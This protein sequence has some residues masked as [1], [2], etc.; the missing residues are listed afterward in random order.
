MLKIRKQ[1]FILRKKNDVILINNIANRRVSKII[2][3][4]LIRHIVEI[5]SNTIFDIPH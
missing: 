2:V 5:Y 1:H 4:V 3:I